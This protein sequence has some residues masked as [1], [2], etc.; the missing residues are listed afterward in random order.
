M[1]QELGLKIKFQKKKS[2]IWNWIESI[3]V[4]NCEFIMKRHG[5]E[6]KIMNS[7]DPLVYGS[8]L[9]NS[10]GVENNWRGGIAAQVLVSWG[11][12]PIL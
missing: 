11:F 7:S 5:V 10:I 3:H 6:F 1:F 9:N 8:V 4:I 2:M 12:F